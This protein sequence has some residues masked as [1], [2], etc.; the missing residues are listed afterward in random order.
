[1]DTD[2]AILFAAPE[3][4]GADTN[5]PGALSASQG[6]RPTPSLATLV[7]PAAVTG[8]SAILVAARW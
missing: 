3:T 6:L 1:L 8:E 5:S 2:A 7:P 4:V